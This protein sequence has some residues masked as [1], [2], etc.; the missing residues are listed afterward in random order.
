MIVGS[1]AVMLDGAPAEVHARV[2]D[3]V[4]GGLSLIVLN[5]DAPDSWEGS[6][7]GGDIHFTDDDFDSVRFLG[8]DPILAGVPDT[9]AHT[10]IVSD[11]LDGGD[12][13]W[14][15]LSDPKCIAVRKLGKGSIYVFQINRRYLMRDRDIRTLLGNVFRAARRGSAKPLLVIDPGDKLV[16]S[17]LSSY[18]EQY[19]L[20]GELATPSSE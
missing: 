8:D 14:T 6:W 16:L 17:L 5:Q 19:R 12:D 20:L 10:K 3:L 11:A 18:G 15:S 1:P 2:L 4:E 9:I 7:L 13:S